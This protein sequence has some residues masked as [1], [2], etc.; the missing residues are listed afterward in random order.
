MPVQLTLTT[1]Q[2]RYI[3]QAIW[4]EI[5]EQDWAMDKSEETEYYKLLALIYDSLGEKY[6]TRLEANLER[7]QS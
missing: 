1:E 2:L 5:D 3:R 7:L 4:T 6:D